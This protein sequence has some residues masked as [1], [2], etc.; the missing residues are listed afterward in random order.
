[1]IADGINTKEIAHTLKLSVKS[2]EVY[3]S[4]IMDKLGIHSVAELVKYAVK[5]EMVNL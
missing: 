1:M 5:N 2:I 3:R 4:Q